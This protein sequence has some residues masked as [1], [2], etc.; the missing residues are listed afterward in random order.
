L[1]LEKLR[2][3]LF[4]LCF[5]LGVGLY[6][7]GKLNTFLMLLICLVSFFIAL[8]NKIFLNKL[9]AKFLFFFA[10][11]LF[12]FF[13]NNVVFSVFLLSTTSFV[14]AFSFLKD[15]N[16]SIFHFFKI[17][18]YIAITT[19]SISFCQYFFTDFFDVIF[20]SFLNESS[21]SNYHFKINRITGVWKEAPRLS[22]ICLFLIPCIIYIDTIKKSFLNKTLIILL[23]I[24]I[25]LTITRVSI[26]VLTLILIKHYT[27]IIDRIFVFR[28]FVFLLVLISFLSFGDMINQ[29][30]LDG[31]YE[32]LFISQ[33]DFT[34]SR[35]TFN[36]LTVFVTLFPL[37]LDNLFLGSGFEYINVLAPFGFSSPHNVIFQLFLIF[38][39]PLSLVFLFSWFKTITPVFQSDINKQSLNFLFK[40][41][42]FSFL[43]FTVFHAELFNFH[44]LSFFLIMY[45]LSFK[46]INSL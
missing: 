7:L 2:N 19:V 1:T 17:C 41:N 37:F 32:R 34:N 9:S 31:K 26:F 3:Y 45:F 24:L 21:Y 5:P 10:L 28:N 38:G 20:S 33:G 27:Q 36:R 15:S 22:M 35:N 42:V 4:L 11:L 13:L 18:R 14:L 23:S 29:I 44:L 6:D 43:I 16:E 39:F 12:S 46:K 30:Y 8:K 25:V 40:I